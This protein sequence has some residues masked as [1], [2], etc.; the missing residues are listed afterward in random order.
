MTAFTKYG[1]FDT[2]ESAKNGL[3]GKNKDKLAKARHD[4]HKLH[5]KV[6]KLNKT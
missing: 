4:L 5:E 2:P 1:R 3:K 6:R